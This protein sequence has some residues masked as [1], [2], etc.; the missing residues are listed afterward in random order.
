MALN[1]VIAGA[2]GAGKGTQCEK[3]VERFGVVHL[4][5]GDI[6]RAAIKG[7]TALGKEFKSC[8]PHS[9]PPRHSTGRLLARDR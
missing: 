3:I 2:P 4:S 7:G 9:L 5:T 1:I 8:A 6:I